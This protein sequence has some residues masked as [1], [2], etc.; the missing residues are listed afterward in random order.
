MKLQFDDILKKS[1]I[2]TS[3]TKINI[4]QTLIQQGLTHFVKHFY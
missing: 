3:I 4:I 1:I 2:S